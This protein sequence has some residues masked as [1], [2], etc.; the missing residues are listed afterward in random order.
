MP[1]SS[2]T[3]YTADPVINVIVMLLVVIGGI[4]FLTWDDIRA[5]KLHVHQYRMQSKVILCTTAI[6]LLFP[7]L[8]FFFFE[9]P[10]SS[11]AGF[12][13]PAKCGS[14]CRTTSLAPLENSE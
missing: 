3:G 2:L 1:F 7:A 12:P 11:L 10:A 9:F 4:G 5:H 13:R 6:L 8:Y 14:T